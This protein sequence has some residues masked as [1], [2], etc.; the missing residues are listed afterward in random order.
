MTKSLLA[1][2]LALVGITT[3]AQSGL[4]L[5]QANCRA[6]VD[7][8]VNPTTLQLELNVQLVPSWGLR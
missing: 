6:L 5:T 4:H 2:G 3:H 7:T 8:P 1:F